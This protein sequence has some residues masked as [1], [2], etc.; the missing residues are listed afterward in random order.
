[1]K[2][3]LSPDATLRELTVT[4]KDREEFVRAGLS[5]MLAQP[6]REEIVLRLGVTGTGQL[7]NYRLERDGAPFLALNGNGHRPWP[8]HEKFDGA[9]TWSTAVM[10]L[11]EVQE[12]RR[13]LGTA[14][15]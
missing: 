5:V 8:A 3:I 9:D 14:R 10:T 15:R 13:D 11:R 6:R 7:P 4:L 1:M 12:L 2:K